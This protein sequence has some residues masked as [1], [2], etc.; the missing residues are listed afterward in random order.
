MGDD[1]DQQIASEN[2]ILDDS[3]NDSYDYNYYDDDEEVPNAIVLTNIDTKQLLT[4]ENLTKDFKDN[5]DS[6]RTRRNIIGYTE[7]EIPINSEFSATTPSYQ[8]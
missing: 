8:R 5:E 3:E 7:D 4:G 6:S 1:L 2:S